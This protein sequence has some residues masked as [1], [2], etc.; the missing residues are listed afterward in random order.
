MSKQIICNLSD[1]NVKIDYNSDFVYTFCK[2]YITDAENFDIAVS[3]SEEK[4]A[5]ERKAALT[6][7]ADY[8]E[9]LC[10]YREIAEKLPEFDR[11]VFHGAAISYGG[12]AYLFTAPSGT[13]KTTHINLWRKALGERVTIINGDK[14]II[15]ADKISTVYGTPWAG[16]ERMQNNVSA[17]L[18]AISIIKR[19][20]ENKIRRL[21]VSEALNHLMRQFYIPHNKASLDKT[22]SLVG[23]VLENTPVYLLECDISDQAFKTS[24]EAL[25]QEKI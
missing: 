22:L 10:I 21:A 14:P 13:G 2:D 5:A 18:E 7:S 16:K 15:K 9:T 6:V 3:A 24:F 11:F 8:C 20:T 17:P 25:T 23:I 19:G 4:I 1:L 12:K